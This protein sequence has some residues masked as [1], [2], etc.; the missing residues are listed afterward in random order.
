M[1]KTAGKPRGKLPHGH[2]LHAG[3]IATGGVYPTHMA[4]E[5]GMDHYGSTD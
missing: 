4:G 5:L 1:K 3:F 2:N